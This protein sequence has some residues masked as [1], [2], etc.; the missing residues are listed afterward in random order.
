MISRKMITKKFVQKL[1]MRKNGFKKD[2]RALSQRELFSVS[3]RLRL[4][5]YE[6]FNELTS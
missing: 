2:P 5:I 3:C 6:L 1:R 4:Q